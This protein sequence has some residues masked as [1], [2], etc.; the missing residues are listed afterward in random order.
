MTG[1]VRRNGPLPAFPTPSGGEALPG[2]RSFMREDG[3]LEP[4][5]KTPAPHSHLQQPLFPTQRSEQQSAKQ[6]GVQ[7][8]QVTPFPRERSC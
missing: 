2:P 1:M 5:I 8:L 7:F 3:A 6:Q 4:L